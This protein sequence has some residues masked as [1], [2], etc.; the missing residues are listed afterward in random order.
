MNYKI[1]PLASDIIITIYVVIS[2]FFRFKYETSEAVTPLMSIV[3][4]ASFVLILW[5]LIK[6]QVLNPNWFGLFK[7]NKNKK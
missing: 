5:V 7:S 6:L 2:L 1:P 3:M 4:G